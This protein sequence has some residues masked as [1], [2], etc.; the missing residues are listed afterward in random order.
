M[1]LL[2]LNP[3]SGSPADIYY[4]AADLHNLITQYI[5]NVKLL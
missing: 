2:G 1:L 5:W 3:S 4:E